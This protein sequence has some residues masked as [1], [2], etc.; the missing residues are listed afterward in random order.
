MPWTAS[1]SL[2][3]QCPAPKSLHLSAD[4]DHNNI[5]FKND[6]ILPILKFFG[7]KVGMKEY[8]GKVEIQGI[9]K[10]KLMGSMENF[11]YLCIPLIEE[12]GSTKRED[13]SPGPVKM[14]ESILATEGGEA[15]LDE[16]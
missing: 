7:E 8:C 14:N 10:L 5:D 15:N 16:L 6:I 1:Q 2:Y 13:S 3:L 12:E 11:P 9:S 4:M